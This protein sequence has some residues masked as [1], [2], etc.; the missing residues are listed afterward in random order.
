[1]KELIQSICSHLV[2]NPDG[3]RI[4]EFLGE[5]TLIYELRCEPNDVGKLIGKNGR[6]VSAMRTLVSTV[7]SRKGKRAVLEVVQ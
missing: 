3:I 6:T 5:K 1:M 2:E 4:T 7:A